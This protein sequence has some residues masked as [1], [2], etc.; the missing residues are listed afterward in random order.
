M[1]HPFTPS[2]LARLIATGLVLWLIAAL[3]IHGVNA[4]GALRGMAWVAV[5]LLTFPLGWT[6]VVT[7]RIVAGLAPGQILGGVAVMTAA[8]VM[9]D[10]VALRL[11]PWLYG[12]DPMAGAALLLFG[13]GAGLAVGYWMNRAG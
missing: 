10:G 2:Q 9:A 7:G 6:F 3:M 13:G 12:S 8:A 11:I 4:V 1:T 5:Y